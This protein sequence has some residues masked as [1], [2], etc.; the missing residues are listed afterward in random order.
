MATI[1][2]GQDPPTRNL[3][4][5]ALRVN[6]IGIVAVSGEPFAEPGLEVKEAE[7]DVD[8]GGLDE[9]PGCDT[10]AGLC[11]TSP[12]KSRSPHSTS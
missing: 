11:P 1:D 12:M 7:P 3:D 5:W 10:T 2:A 9:I 4:F 6:D 8:R